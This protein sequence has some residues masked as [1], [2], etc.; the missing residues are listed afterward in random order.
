MIDPSKALSQLPDGL[1]IPLI[2]EH[3]SIVQNFMEKR[4]SPS[5]LSGGRFCEIIYTILNGHSK[6]TYPSAPSKP[7]DLVSACRALEANTNVPRSFQILIPRMLPA[8]YEIRN[9]RG[10]GHVGGDVDPNEMDATAVLSMSSW[11]LAELVRVFHNLS[12]NEAQSTVNA[13]VERRIPLVWS[14]DGIR[15]VLDPSLSLKDTVLILL[16]SS[17]T[18]ISTVNLQSWTDYKDKKY[19]LR[20][21]RKLHKERLIELSTDE[22]FTQL[23]PPGSAYVENLVAN[24]P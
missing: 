14:Q 12:A 5:E 18:K 24:N 23:L 8:L 4:W 11:I 2:E 10:V 17:V 19:F 7:K 9:N 1:R 20:L 21:L 6:G 13:L 15:R 3:R 16:G 22:S